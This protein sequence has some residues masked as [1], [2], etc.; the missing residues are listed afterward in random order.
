MNNPPIGRVAEYRVK[1]CPHEKL[2]Y[3]VR[4]LYRLHE[5]YLWNDG[6]WRAKETGTRTDN[7]RGWYD[8]E[9]DAAKMLRRHLQK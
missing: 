3:V 6:E 9:E 8:T 5:E 2:W 4:Y 7:P 1:E